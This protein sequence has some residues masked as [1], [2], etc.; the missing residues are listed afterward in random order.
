MAK[1]QRVSR[2]RTI[3][4]KVRSRAKKFTLPL[5]LVGGMVPVVVGVWNRKSS[6]TEIGQ[7]LQR[8]FTGIEPTD[9]K[10]KLDNLRLGAMPLVGG[11]LVHMIASKLGLN[12]AIGRSGLP[13]I[14]I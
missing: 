3:Y 9:G 5:A 2:T 14:R 10:F 6:G 11:F 13:V 1:R 8:G 7:Y 12:R 4:K